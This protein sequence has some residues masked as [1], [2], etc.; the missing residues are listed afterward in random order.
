MGSISWN[1]N[2]GQCLRTLIGHIEGVWSVAVTPDGSK[3]VSG[4]ED[5]TVKVWDLNTGQC[6]CTLTGHNGNVLSVAVTE[7][8]PAIVDS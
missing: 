4:S 1:L 3:I 8:V 5:N 7:C 2:T 6:L